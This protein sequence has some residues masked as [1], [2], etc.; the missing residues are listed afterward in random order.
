MLQ[1]ITEQIKTFGCFPRG[2]ITVS[3]SLDKSCYKHDDVLGLKLEVRYKSIYIY[4]FL[5]PI[6]ILIYLFSD[7]EHDSTGL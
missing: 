3:V 4:F 1:D 7:Y 5:W 6:L 2:Y